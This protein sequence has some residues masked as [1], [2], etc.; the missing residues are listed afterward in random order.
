MKQ[1]IRNLKIAF[2][3]L[4]VLSIALGAGLVYQQKQSQTTLLAVAGEN[5]AGLRQRYSKGGKILSA[6]GIPLAYSEDDQRYYAEDPT[7][8]MS[9]SQL[10]GD[11]T[12][13]MSNTIETIYQDEILGNQRNI[14]EQLLMDFSGRGMQGSN[15]ELTINANLNSY[16]YELM[17]NYRGTAVL[18]N[19]KTGD[20]AAMVSSP[21][22]PMEN[23][24]NYEDLPDSSLFNRALMGEY[25]PASTFKIFTAAAWLSSDQMDP[26]FTLNDDGEPLRPNGARD[27]G[28]GEVDLNRAFTRS[29]NVYFG[30]LAVKIGADNFTKFLDQTNLK[31]IDHVDRLDKVTASWD[32]SA[33][34]H[35]DALLSWFGAGQPVGELKLHFTPVDLA[36][37]AGA[38]A[39]GGDLKVPHVVSKITNPL[40]QVKEE[41]KVES[42]G[43]MFSPQVA[44]RLQQLMLE[45]VSSDESIQWEARIDGYE[46]GGKSGTLEVETAEGMTEN[47]LWTGFV[48]DSNYPYAVA[49]I[50]EDASDSGAS[51][52]A[53]GGELLAAAISNDGG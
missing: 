16:A 3:V 43:R 41:A 39:N 32:N 30:E 9:V 28:H 20:I 13:H 21:A 48:N 38:V 6:D 10:V 44:S 25:A 47:A 7:L 8:Q 26:S 22:A 49:V 31:K 46:V 2:A 1:L 23:I 37:T 11:Y 24:I 27:I 4:M 5:K 19:Y 34:R 17:E 40:N 33:A 51:A 36:L 18:L 42:A 35:D 14:L 15:I 12:H 53:I 29:C 45:A 52:T 50:V